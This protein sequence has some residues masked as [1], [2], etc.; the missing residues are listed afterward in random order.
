V[1]AA[2]LLSRDSSQLASCS[3][4]PGMRLDGGRLAQ[5]PRPVYAAFVG[6][7]CWMWRG[8]PRPAAR[9]SLTVERLAW[10]FG[11]DAADAVVR[12]K[13]DVAGEFEV[14]SGSCAGPLLA[15]LPLASAARA[16]GRSEL[17]AALLASPPESTQDLCIFASGDPRDGQWALS[18]ASFLN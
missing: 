16:G 6:D 4:R 13:T 12:P 5:G 17:N 15:R 2:A 11:D 3:G 1:E 18:R 7:M 8:A 14:H 9:I 10:R